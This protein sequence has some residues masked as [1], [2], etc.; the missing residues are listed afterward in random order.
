MST[1]F[2]ILVMKKSI[3]IKTE[4]GGRI[5]FG[6]LSEDDEKILLQAVADKKMPD[7][8]MELRFNSGF[9]DYEGVFNKGDEGDFG[10]EGVISFD[11][12]GTIEIPKDTNESFVDGAYLVYLSLSKVSIE[13]EFS[14][15]DGIFESEKFTE[16]SVPVNLPDCIEHQLYGHP[17]Y[18][19]VTDYLYD[20]ESI[21]EYD[22]DLCDR[23]YSDQTTF[24]VVK[25][26]QLSAV[27]TNN[28]GEEDWQ[29]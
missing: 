11:P 4:P 28:D 9:R 18:N 16:V 5:C 2:Q 13:F 17:D 22:E 27:Y 8:L 21:E 20:G 29:S 10:N 3:Y 19:V 14:P 26:G 12:D 24:L 7:E 25:N 6:R 1:I 15:R 23:G